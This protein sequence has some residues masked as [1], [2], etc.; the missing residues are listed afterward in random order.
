VHA[1][2]TAAQA[3]ARRKKVALWDTKSSAAERIDYTCSKHA[4][5][6]SVLSRIVLKYSG[7][8]ERHC[9]SNIAFSSQKVDVGDTKTNCECRDELHAWNN[10]SYHNLSDMS[11]LEWRESRELRTTREQ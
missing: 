4:H 9:A 5:I 11:V 8:K 1:L 6:W 10:T 7:G 2:H 3:V